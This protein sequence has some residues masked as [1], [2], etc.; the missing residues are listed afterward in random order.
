MNFRTRSSA[1]LVAVSLLFAGIA[2]VLANRWM[3]ER[4]A[5]VEATR[6]RTTRVVVAATDIPFGTSIEA[7][8]LASVDMLVNAVTSGSYSQ[9]S[10]VIGK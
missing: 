9:P 10:V 5:A 8:H 2:A 4:T 7:R 3:N 6:P 1:I